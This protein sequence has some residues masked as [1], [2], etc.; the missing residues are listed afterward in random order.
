MFGGNTLRYNRT[1][2]VKVP[3]I[4]QVG[5][6]VRDLEKTALE[7]THLLGIGP[8]DI[9]TL[10]T[11]NIYDRT[12]HGKPACFGIKIAF[13]QVG[14]FELE[15]MT[16]IE[17]RTD[18][19][20]FLEKHGEGANH[21]QY[22]VDSVDVMDA[23]VKS[24]TENGFPSLTYARYGDNGGFAYMDTIRALGTVWEP[25]KMADHFVGPVKRLPNVPTIEKLPVVQVKEVSM[26]S[27]VIKNLEGAINN[28]TK[29]LGIAPWEVETLSTS[30]VQRYVYRGGH[31]CFAKKTGRATGGAIDIELV[32]PLSGTSSFHDFMTR[33]GQGIHHLEFIVEDIERTTDLMKKKGVEKIM[34]GQ[35]TRGHFAYYDTEEPLKIIW[36]AVQTV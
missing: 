17:G 1:P 34:S 27:I 14:S 2:L 10:L 20:D 11:P 16:T 36:K 32:E 3:F 31:A 7:Y 15:L 24:L 18:Y 21:L 5:I 30:S 29:I 23:H 12:Y 35:D 8:W 9:F 6:V 25:V 4:H 19:D 33:H 22:W 28:Y 13:A 26:V